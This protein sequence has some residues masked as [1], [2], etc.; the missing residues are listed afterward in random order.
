L[1]IFNKAKN[2]G[3]IDNLSSLVNGLVRTWSQVPRRESSELPK[4]SQENPRTA[5]IT[6]IAKAVASTPWKIYSKKDIRTSGKAAVPLPDHPVYDLIDN[7]MRRYP[8]IDGFTMMYVTDA[9]LKL[10]GEVFWL[11][12]RDTPNGP[13]T[14]LFLVLSPWVVTRPTAGNPN[15]IVY[16][17]GVTSGRALTVS[18]DDMIWF[19]KVDLTDPYSN[20][21]ADA[22]PLID[23]FSTDEY[24]AKVQKNLFYNDATPPYVVQMPGAS[25]RQLEDAKQGWIQKIGG[26][27][28]QRKPAFVGWDAKI[29]PLAISPKEMDLIESRKYLRDESLQFF[30]LPPEIFGIVENSNR[31]TIDSSFYLFNK[32]VLRYEFAF[33]E[34]AIN[35]QLIWKEFDKDLCFQFDQEVQEDE[36]FKLDMMNA[37]MTNGTITVDEWRAAFK[38]PPLPNDKRN[39]RH[40]T[41]STYEVGANDKVEDLAPTT[42]ATDNT[43]DDDKMDE[44][45]KDEDKSAIITIVDAHT[46]EKSNDK[47][48]IVKNNDDRRMAIWKSFDTRATRQEPAFIKAVKKYADTQKSKLVAELNKSIGNQVSL[49]N[50]VNKSIDSV[51]G[52]K[53]DKALKSALAP[54]W[55]A[56]LQQG[57][58]HAESMMGNHKSK[59]VKAVS[60]STDVIND[61]LNAWVEKYGLQKAKEINTT[62]YDELRKKL[63]AQ[64]SEGISNSDT[65]EDIKREILDECD[66]V[67]D[68]MTNARAQNLARTETTGSISAGSYITMKDAG[69]ERRQWNC[70]GDDRSRDDHIEADGQIVGI[71]E[72]YTVGSSK[73][74]YPGDPNGPADEICQC[75]CFETILLPGEE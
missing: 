73:L 25:E 42:T 38:F 15:F 24:A 60:G 12:V 4:L 72:Y 50:D 21:S 74:L 57:N 34:R 37:G 18:P 63:Q 23:E 8:E 51:F 41:L 31:A 19:K 71:D 10:A 44:G 64:V 59:S 14:Q 55:L 66:G 9:L 69:I 70:V 49:K 35:R 67:Y 32:N 58:E 13:P 39:V 47:V 45:V 53:A 75:R 5:P 20:G 36:A 27:L 22:K 33:L 11:K 29:T 40:L 61:L 52:D 43:V 3:V 6:V 56:S 65:I 48:K 1:S 7:P 62:T 17:Y 54:A 46:I 68:K 30:Q 28:N 16:P 2:H 26:F